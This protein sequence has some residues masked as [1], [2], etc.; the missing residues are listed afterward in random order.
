MILNIKCETLL[1]TCI[2]QGR[3]MFH[4]FLYKYS[5]EYRKAKSNKKI[6]RNLNGYRKKG[7]PTVLNRKSLQRTRVLS[8]LNIYII[9]ID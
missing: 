2:Q 6:I 4:T 5:K 7:N 3:Q 8:Q 9:I 1:T